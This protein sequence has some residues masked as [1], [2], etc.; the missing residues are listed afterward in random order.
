MARYPPQT[1][2]AQS[3][4]AKIAYQVSGTGPPNLVMVPGLVSHLDIQW[5]QTGYRRFVRA[6]ERGGR[7]IRLDKRGTGLSDPAAELPTTQERVRDVA[8]V[9]AAAK[10]PRAVLFGLS[11]G[12][13]AAIAFAAAYPGR[14]QGLILYGTSYRG[15][16][17]AL[18][19][20]Y[21][22]MVRRWGQGQIIDLVA[23]SLAGPQARREAGAFERAAASPAMAA[24]LIESLGLIDVRD[25]MSG[26]ALPTLVLHRQG[27]VI[28]VADARMVADQIPGA[29]LRILPGQDHLPWAGDWASVAGEILAFLAQV[30]PTRKERAPAADLGQGRPPGGGL[31]V[32][33]RSGTP[34]GATGGRGPHERGYRRPAVLARAEGALASARSFLFDAIGRIWATVCGETNLTSSSGRWS[35]WRRIRPCGRARRPLT[36]CSGSHR[37]RRRRLHA[38]SAAALLAGRPHRQAGRDSLFSSGRDQAYAKVRLGHRPAHLL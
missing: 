13:R 11:D 23:P 6:L 33:D 35:C 36:G 5:Q 2:Y 14:T 1:R 9:M 38:P 15:P 21:R 19:R 20:R 27:D 22:S 3:S 31:A 37:R 17:A 16:R 32:A 29:T 26:L 8:A 28:P 12:G 4:G 10:S 24:A 7:L 34:G 18:L 25:L 30:A